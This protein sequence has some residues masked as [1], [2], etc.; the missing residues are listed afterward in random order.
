MSVAKVTLA[1]ESRICHKLTKEMQNNC[2]LLRNGH[3]K[4]VKLSIICVALAASVTPAVSGKIERACIKSDRPAS[5]STCSC[6][7]DVAD[8]KLS[9]NDQTA[10]AKFFKDPQRAQDTRQSDNRSTEAF[11]KRYKEFGQLAAKHC[12]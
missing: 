7:Q 3:M 11:W 10:A 1:H 4:L 12:S 2:T 6:I 8:V 9:S 5:R